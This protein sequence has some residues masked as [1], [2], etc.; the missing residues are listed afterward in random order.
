MGKILKYIE[1]NGTKFQCFKTKKISLDASD[2]DIIAYNYDDNTVVQTT[3]SIFAETDRSRQSTVS[4]RSMLS[5]NNTPPPIFRY[6]LDG[7]R[8]TYKVDD[9]SIGKKIGCGCIIMLFSI[10]I[11]LI[12]K[13]FPHSIAFIEAS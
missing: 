9:I 5:G 1:G 4:L 6:F 8:H 13:L 11:D 7:L 10:S 3:K 2:N 12:P